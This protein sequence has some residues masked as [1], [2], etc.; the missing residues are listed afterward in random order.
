MGS[1]RTTREGK[2]AIVRFA[3]PPHNFVDTE[4]VDELYALVNDLERDNEIRAVIFAGEEPGAWITHYAPKEILAGAKGPRFSYRRARAVIAL[5]GCLSRSRVFASA[6]RRT[7]AR[8]LVTMVRLERTYEAITRS[9]KV[10]I[11]AVDGI[12]FGT[13][14]IL[15]LVCDIRIAARELIA[16]GLP[17]PV[18]GFVPSSGVT[19][20]TRLVGPGRAIDLVLSGRYMSAADAEATGLVHAVVPRECL[21]EA[22]LDRATEVTRRS[23]VDVRELKRTV[24]ES[25]TR[26][27]PASLAAERASFVTSV[28]TKFTEHAMT[29][30][31]ADV[32]K[33]ADP[34]ELLGPWERARARIVE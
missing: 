1:F 16:F 11:A 26:P 14:F 18:L 25:A 24:Y 13:A 5:I 31:V 8:G 15:S 10:Y 34:D 21:F 2:V 27:L 9:D 12:I 28:A 30:F 22:A 29:S 32:N 20:L 19:R 6:L 3:K 23:S 4:A 33:T 17:E 7:P